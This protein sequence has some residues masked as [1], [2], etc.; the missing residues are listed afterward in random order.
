[1]HEESIDFHLGEALHHLETA[2]N[3]SI[4]SV[5][6]NEGAKKEIA[7]KWEHFFGQFIGMV[8]EKGKKAR[9]NPLAWISFSKIR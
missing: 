1:L 9:V 4:H 7:P 2:L 6:E 5:L 3:Q 8:K